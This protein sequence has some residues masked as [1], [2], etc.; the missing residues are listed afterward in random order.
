MT[1]NEVINLLMKNRYVAE[2]LVL[3]RE[4]EVTLDIGIGHPTTKIRIYQTSAQSDYSFHFTLSQHVI[5]A[6]TDRPT[7]AKTES[8]ALQLAVAMIEGEIEMARTQ[9]IAPHAIVFE[10]NEHF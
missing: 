5:G 6:E 9:G 7:A 8:E 3:V 1:T 4:C 2:C 10:P